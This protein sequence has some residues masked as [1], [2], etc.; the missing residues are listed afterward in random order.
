MNASSHLVALRNLALQFAVSF[1]LKTAV[2][3][4]AAGASFQTA[5][6]A[7]EISFTQVSTSF[8]GMI[9]IDYFEPLN[10]V[11][12]TANYSSG[13]PFNFQ[14]I[15]VDGSHI[16]HSNVNQIQDELK[17]ATVRSANFGGYPGGGGFA[18]GTMFAGNGVSGQIMKIDPDGTVTSPWATMPNAASAGFFRGSLYVDRTGVFGGD[19]IGVTTAGNIYRVNSSGAATQL[20]TSAGVHLEG[21]L[22]VPNDPSVWGGLAGKIVA[23]AE[24]QMRLWAI[25]AAGVKVSWTVSVA[26]EDLDWIMPNENFFGV[27]YAQGRLLGVPAE[28]FQAQGLVGK[29]LA[30]QETSGALYTLS[31]NF[32][33]NAP[34]FDPITV[35]GAI[36]PNQWEHVTFAPAGIAEIRTSLPTPKFGISGSLGT[37]NDLDTIRINQTA[38]ARYG[39]NGSTG[40]PPEALANKAVMSLLEDDVGRMWL[41]LVLDKSGDST[42]GGL[43]L[44]L[45]GNGQDLSN[46]GLAVVDDSSD[47]F[48]YANGSGMF[49]WTWPAGQTDGVVVY[50]PYRRISS[51]PLSAW[52]IT[53]STPSVSGIDG[54]L[55]NV[56]GQQFDFGGTGFNFTIYLNPLKITAAASRKTH[57]AGGDFDV[58]LPTTGTPGIECRGGG[59]T[60]DYTIVVTFSA[61]VAVTGSPQAQVTMGTATI[62]TGGVSN[63]GAVTVAGNVVT[64]PLTN[65]A[66]EQTINVTLNGANNAG[67]DQPAINVVIPMS[68]LLG[69]TNG[70]GSV[71]SSD[72]SQTKARIGQAIDSTNFR[73]DLNT[74]NSINSTDAS[75]VKSNI[76]HG[77]P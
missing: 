12:T 17:L 37:H 9:G 42:G 21:L 32:A 38:I 15:A 6:K 35:I 23:G 72:A 62:G 19:L 77:L 34:Q 11:V 69:D 54:F 24:Q 36:I 5:A 70:N 7:A 29:I 43:T 51:D 60:N 58:N 20:G 73:S 14:R 57:G 65:V 67:T 1:R 30:V 49:T 50:L 56:D 27:N 59:A 3:L 66:D 76:G 53:F 47:P 22:T 41:M 25:D 26:V 8:N 13:I 4:F 28:Q 31:W 71:N 40:S 68:R 74:S 44:Q 46:S 63:G 45:A 55:L 48:S 52:S 64:I 39:Y 75:Q 2:A 16:A 18:P 10:Q 61:N 33:T